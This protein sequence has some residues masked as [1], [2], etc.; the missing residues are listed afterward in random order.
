MPGAL[1]SHGRLCVCSLLQG[2]RSG[3]GF[4]WKVRQASFKR[5][6]KNTEEDHPSAACSS[7]Q[8]TPLPKS[9]SREETEHGWT[10]RAV[11]RKG[12]ER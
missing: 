12:K 4:H 10:C 5:K 6:W 7:S 2:H 8:T 1:L 11:V 9:A 3:Y